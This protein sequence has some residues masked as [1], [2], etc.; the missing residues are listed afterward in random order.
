MMRSRAI[1]AAAPAIARSATRRGAASAEPSATAFS[2]SRTDRAAALSALD[3]GGDV[4]I[5]D[6]ATFFAAPANLASLEALCA[7]H[8]D[9][10]LLAGSTECRSVA[11]QVAARDREDHLAGT[12]Q[13]TWLRWRKGRRGLAIG[14]M[15]SHARA[16]PALARLDPDLGELIA[17]FRLGPGCALPVRSAAISPTA[18]RSAISPRP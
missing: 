1:C 4:F 15:V 6:D 8:P 12:R 7:A 17:P 5:G 13:R 10:T 16:H 3:D 11:D 2:A 18:R 9:A 14:A